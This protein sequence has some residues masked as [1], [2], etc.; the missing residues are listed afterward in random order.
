MRSSQLLLLL[1]NCLFLL[2]RQTFAYNRPGCSGWPSMVAWGALGD[3]LDGQLHGPF[4]VYDYKAKCLLFQNQKNVR[5]LKQGDGICMHVH[6]CVN[7][8]CDPWGDLN[9]PEFSVEARSEQDVKRALDFANAH[10]IE[11]SVKSSGHTYMSQSSASGSLLIWL[12]HMPLDHTIAETTDSCM[13][14]ETTL[15]VT[16]GEPF[17][18]AWFA[19]KTNYHMVT[20]NWYV[21]NFCAWM[22]PLTILLLLLMLF[23]IFSQLQSNS[24]VCRWLAVRRRHVGDA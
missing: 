12:R 9:L 20:G 5:I 2:T 1:L 24:I 3:S 7:K 11:V 23:F 4:S 10:D 6:T 18:D 17:D 8:R 14:T 22:V 16:G 15:R 21:H 19:V 13:N